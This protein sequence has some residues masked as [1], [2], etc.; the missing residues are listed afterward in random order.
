MSKILE[1]LQLIRLKKHTSTKICEDQHGF[2][3]SH[4]ISQHLNI[5]DNDTLNLNKTHKTAVI[6]S[7]V[8][9]A[10]DEVW[11]DSL[12]CELIDFEVFKYLI[13]IL[14]SFFNDRSFHNKIEEKSFTFS[15][16]LKGVS[17]GSPSMKYLSIRVDKTLTSTIN[18]AKAVKFLLY[19]IYPAPIY[20][21]PKNALYTKPIYVL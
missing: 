14:V 11:H 1:K 9:K 3:N 2:R 21:L 18:K 7:D 10:F 19:P 16:I 13:T 5:I 12:I 4:I 17:R 15:N 8:V 6:L 20:Q